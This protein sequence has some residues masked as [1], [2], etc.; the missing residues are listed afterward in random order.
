MNPLCNL[1]SL[2]DWCFIRSSSTS[3]SSMLEMLRIFLKRGTNIYASHY[4]LFFPAFNL[5]LYLPAHKAASLVHTHST[6]GTVLVWTPFL[7]TVTELPKSFFLRVWNIKGWG[8]MQVLVDRR[9]GKDPLYR[10][11]PREAKEISRFLELWGKGLIRPAGQLH[12][13]NVVRMLG[14]GL[15]SISKRHY[16]NTLR[17]GG[18]KGYTSQCI[19]QTW[20]KG[21][22]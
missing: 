22:V 3:S 4:K 15:R 18:K 11:C 12:R 1:S 5:L 13:D 17:E 10:T 19:L 20:P 9:T 6:I 8:F 16:L 14:S 7:H 21:T 2:P